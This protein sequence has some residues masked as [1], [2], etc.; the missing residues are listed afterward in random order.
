MP[1]AIHT[2]HLEA[3]RKSWFQQNLPQDDRPIENS[4]YFRLSTSL[5]AP[6]SD[7]AQKH[8]PH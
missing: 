3:L 8:Q 2:L 6:K 5:I 1:Q 7:R 4:V